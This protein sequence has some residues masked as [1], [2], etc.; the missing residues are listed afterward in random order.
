[1]DSADE[2]TDFIVVG[3]GA[4]AMCS[5]LTM[6]AQGRQV[7]ML[8]KSELVGGTTARS[9]GVMWIPNNRFLKQDGIEDSY[10][11]ALLYLEGLCE[12]QD[13]TPGSTPLRR[14]TYLQEA[15]RMLD[16]LLEQGIHIKR[17]RDWPD[18]YDE[19][20]GGLA[21]G[22]CVGADLFD[23][24]ELGEWKEK[25]RPGFMQYPVM[26]DEALLMTNFKRS[27]H[28]LRILLRMLGRSVYA[29]L[30]G[31]EYIS[32]GQ[33][34]QGRLLQAL[35]NSGV[36]LR[37]QTPVQELLIRDGRVIGVLTQK[38]GKPWRIEARLGVLVAAG[39]FA[40]NQAM[41][42]QYL[43]G[44]STLWTSAAPT[45]TG[46]MIQEMMRQGAAVAQ[47][48]EMV[49]NQCTLPPGSRLGDI[50]APVQGITAKPH[51]I[52]VDQTGV[53][54]M[55]EGGS[56]MAYCKGM[57]ERNQTAPAVPSWA[58]LDSQYMKKYMLAGTMP[59]SQ[60]PQQWYDSGYLKKA[61]SLAQL[62][63]LID[64]EPA[65]LL[66]TVERFNGFVARNH[67][68]DFQRGERAYDRWLGDFLH[69]PSETLGTIQQGPF[70][71]LQ[72]L[73]GDV[74]TYGGVVTDECARVLRDDGSVIPG[75]YAAGVSTA[76]VMGRIYP[77]AGSSIGP[78]CTWGYVAARHAAGVIP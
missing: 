25:L 47:M 19:R 77:G 24:N 52:L 70:Y 69:R 74:S 6:L 13:D 64:I 49:G 37:P 63:Q 29:K 22:R 56:Y 34:L 8:E 5:A 62:A 11:Q 57:L 50:R 1:M 7:L 14:Q 40:H 15:P 71:A 26:V 4:G 36:D 45:D 17:Y 35:L 48:D 38:Q 53:R 61:D 16:F 59:G 39:G 23:V 28:S 42:D 54:Y 76:S 20:P 67:D 78:A 10:E 12:G 41:R 46:E 3:S 32:A 30:T 21:V 51:A 65:T 60:K 33:A 55:N 43:P 72:V 58:I 2:T 68:A 9:G 66:A 75:L 18:Y 27:W 44:T 73:P 31:K